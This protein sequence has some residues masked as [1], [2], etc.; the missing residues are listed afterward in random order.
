MI[1]IKIGLVV[2][3]AVCITLSSFSCTKDNKKKNNVPDPDEI[4]L[5]D[6]DIEKKYL[7]E[8]F[9]SDDLYRIVIVMTK[10]P[11][12]SVP[13]AVLYK[14]K[15]RAQVSLERTIASSDFQSDRNTRA[16]ILSLIDQNGSLS[17]KEIE[18]RRYDVYYFDIVKKN[19]KNH[20][21]NQTIRR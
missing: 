4:P 5:S 17:K 20:L 11:A 10:D 19:L 3:S 6:V 8:G 2:L 21:R 9:I 12:S 18:H 15:K 14:A 1:G 16:E 7:S 13:D